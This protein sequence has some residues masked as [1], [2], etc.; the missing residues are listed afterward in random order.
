[1]IAQKKENL[2]VKVYLLHTVVI[3]AASLVSHKNFLR[4]KVVAVVALL[5]MVVEEV[6]LFFL[7]FFEYFGGC[8]VKSGSSSSAGC[9]CD[10][11]GTPELQQLNISKNEEPQWQQRSSERSYFSSAPK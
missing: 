4:I 7:R 2:Y 1:M 3:H 8:S 5:V 10:G 11:G 6:S 9:C